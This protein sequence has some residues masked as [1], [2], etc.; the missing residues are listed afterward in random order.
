LLRIYEGVSFLGA[1]M[2]NVPP[3]D[4]AVNDE[5]FLQLA[6]EALRRCV[7]AAKAGT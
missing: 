2:N 4:L 1:N 5:P 3:R 7:H 6:E